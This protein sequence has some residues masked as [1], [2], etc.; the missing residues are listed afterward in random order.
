MKTG[1]WVTEGKAPT[2]TSACVCGIR[3]YGAC[4]SCWQIMLLS[5]A[6]K[7]HK[8][9]DRCQ[10]LSPLR[11]ATKVFNESTLFNLISIIV[12]CQTRTIQ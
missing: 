9:S 6:V 3:Y 1:S 5:V 12:K 2:P 8:T 4:T 10:T 11:T 7:A